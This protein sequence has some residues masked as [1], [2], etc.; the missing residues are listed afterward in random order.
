MFYATKIK[1]VA[2]DKAVDEQGKVL[3]FI[4]YLP[5]EVGDTVFTDGTIIFGNATPKGSAMNFFLK[6][7]VDVDEDGFALSEMLQ[8]IWRS[9]IRKGEK[10]YVYIDKKYVNLLQNLLDKTSKK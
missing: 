6:H 5:V 1:E 10:I 9:A 8:F 2:G 3:S 4:G 7:E